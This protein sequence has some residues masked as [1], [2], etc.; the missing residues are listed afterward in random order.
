MLSKIVLIFGLAQTGVVSS[1]TAVYNGRFVGRTVI[2]LTFMLRD[3][4]AKR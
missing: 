4:S 3:S 2:L 1:S